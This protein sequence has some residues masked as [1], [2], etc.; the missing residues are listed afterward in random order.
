[1]SESTD[2]FRK[3]S[4]SSVSQPRQITIG[5]INPL[6]EEIRTL[7][8]GWNVESVIYYNKLRGRKKS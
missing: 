7:G 6:I 1:L 2:I 8:D 4:R 3:I 5:R